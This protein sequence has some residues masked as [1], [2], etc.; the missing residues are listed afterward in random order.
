MIRMLAKLVSI[1]GFLYFVGYVVFAGQVTFPLLMGILV[2]GLFF[3][4][5]FEMVKTVDEASNYWD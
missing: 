2:A 5:S 4:A 3:T 1:I